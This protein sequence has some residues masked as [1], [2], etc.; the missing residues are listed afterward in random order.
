[1]IKHI[2][3][4]IAIFISTVL[5]GQ[6]NQISLNPGYVNQS[7]YSMQNGEILNISNEDWDIAFSTDA[8]SSTIRTNDG[9]GVELYVYSSGDTSAWNNINSNDLNNLTEFMY[10]TDTSWEYGAFDINQTGG[11]DYGWGVYNLQTHHIIGDSIFIIKTINSSWKKLWVRSKISGDYDIQYA[12]LDGS[13]LVNTTIEASNYIAKNFVYYSLNDEL[14][15]DREPDKDDWDIT[16]TKY[17]TLY[18]T[19][20]GTFLP[21]S[22]T[23]VLQNNGIV[24]AEADNISTPLAY[25]NYSAHTFSNLINTIGFDWKV[26][27][28]SYIII[29]NLCYFIRDKSNNIWRLTF[30]DFDGTTTGNIEFNTEL[31]SSTNIKELSEISNLQAYPNPANLGEDI[32][33]KYKLLSNQSHGFV[34]LYD[35]TGR[36]IYSE[37]LENNGLTHHNI[38][39]ESLNR[40][41]YFVSIN[42]DGIVK[43]DRIIIY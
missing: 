8:F 41:V 36:E 27:Q 37:E 25:T 3:L 4:L 17:M 1:M 13:N 12:N 32:Q 34:K 30:T 15:I 19:T 6:N 18:P 33:I 24:V 2:T 20:Q 40:G 42:I 38:G 23:G 7:F 35:L 28:G 14:V 31:I 22:V 16:F 29:D 39:T 10:N 9:K 11:F 43:T 21:Y 26:F 5:I